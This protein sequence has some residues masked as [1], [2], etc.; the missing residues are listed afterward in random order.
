MHFIRAL[1]V[2]A[3]FAAFAHTAPGQTF[4]F[5]NPGAI[6]DG[7]SSAAGNFGTPRVMTAISTVAN[8]IQDIVLTVTMDHTWIGDLRVKLSYTPAGSPTTTT[9]IIM[10]RT[11][12]SSSTSVGESSNLSGTYVFVLGA[13]PFHTAAIP[14]GDT[15]I[16]PTGA[17]AP[18]SS[19]LNGTH[20]VTEFADFFRGQS[21]TGT[22]TLTFEDGATP[23]TG[24]VTSASIAL[25]ARSLPCL[26]DFNTDGV[27]N[28]AD[29]TF[30]L[31]RFGNT[32]Q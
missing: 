13:T 18:A 16:L 28:S 29:L 1:V 31:G 19:N 30:F 3:C 20:S 23:D 6:A 5:N 26:A 12:A 14:L 7:T 11:G 22:W 24:T 9:A 15:Q 25:Q 21:G 2:A 32:C 10:N 4:F 27:V 8:P 17:Y